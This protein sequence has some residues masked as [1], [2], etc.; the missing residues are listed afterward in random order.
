ML[1]ESCHY[2]QHIFLRRCININ[3]EC[4]EKIALNCSNLSSINLGY[5][6]MIT[7]ASLIALGKH[8]HRL[9]SINLTATNITDEGVIGLV[10]QGTVINLQEVHLSRCNYIT[11][12]AIECVLMNCKNIKYLLFTNCPKTTDASRF[13]IEEYMLNSTNKKMEQ[14]TWTIY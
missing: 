12:E 11:D 2:L 13:A 6:S 10:T 4:I 9:K 14:V 5:C 8:C 7:D 1:V 3:D